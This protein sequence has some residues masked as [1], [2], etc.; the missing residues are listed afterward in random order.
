MSK[1]KV[2]SDKL[3]ISGVDTERKKSEK[4]KLFVEHH[5]WKSVL[6]N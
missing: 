4:E 1:C 3:P 6:E 5:L 2:R